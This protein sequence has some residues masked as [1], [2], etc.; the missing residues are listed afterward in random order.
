[1]LGL[2]DLWKISKGSAMWQR[3]AQRLMQ[4]GLAPEGAMAAQRPPSLSLLVAVVVSLS[5]VVVV[6]EVVVVVVVVVVAVVV[7]AV[8]VA[9]APTPLASR[10]GGLEHGRVDTNIARY[11]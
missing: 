2:I 4:P 3:T 10:P 8:V 7:V 11:E 6:V 9:A 1:M 5:L